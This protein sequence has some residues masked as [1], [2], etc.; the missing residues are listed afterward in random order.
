M[1]Q[2]QQNNQGNNPD[3]EPN[4]PNKNQQSGADPSNKPNEGGKPE[5]DGVKDSHG[6]PGINLERHNKEIAEKDAKIAELQAKV[7]EAAKTE[8]GR[9]DLL[10]ELQSLRADMEDVKLTAKLEVAGCKS[11]KAAK[12][13]LP[14]F[15]NDIEKLKAAEPWLFGNSKPGSTG[16]PPSGAPGKT[17][18]E[19]KEEYRRRLGVKPKKN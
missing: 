10:K 19:E 15:E 11:P 6:Q 1:S 3:P 16:L 9:A 4:E 7:D 2:D 18:E 14:D 13:L 8:Q 5:D 17:E 12:A